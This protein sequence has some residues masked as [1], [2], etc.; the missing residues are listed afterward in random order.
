MNFSRFAALLGLSFAMGAPS[1]FDYLGRLRYAPRPDL[2]K[3]NHNKGRDLYE[4]EKFVSENPEYFMCA[5]VIRKKK[6]LTSH[7]PKGY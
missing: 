3:K 2:S 4:R 1:A 6:K 7:L 5:G